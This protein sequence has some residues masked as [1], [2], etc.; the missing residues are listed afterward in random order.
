ML[1]LH[2]WSDRPHHRGGLSGERRSMLRDRASSEE[3]LQ[4]RNNADADAVVYDDQA[5]GNANTNGHAAD[6]ATSTF[7]DS[8]SVWGVNSA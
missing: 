6:S 5:A 8:D 2:Q 1:V 4:G 7:A 3:A